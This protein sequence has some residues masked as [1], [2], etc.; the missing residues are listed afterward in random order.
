MR[1]LIWKEWHEQSWKLGFGCIVLSAMIVIGLNA[2]I[3]SDLIMVEWVCGI[4]VTILPIISATGLIPAERS[5]GT[6]E[7]LLAMPIAPWRILLAKTIAG[8]VLCVGPVMAAAIFTVIIAN[9][10]EATNADLLDLY[11]RT[12]LTSV[13]LLVWIM[14]LTIR[15]PTEGRAGLLAMGVLLLWVMVSG[16]LGIGSPRR[17]GFALSPF[18]FMYKFFAFQNDLGP[19]PSFILVLAVQAVVL[20]GVWFLARRTFVGPV[21]GQS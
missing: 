14:A 5:E 8:V 16:A 13:A 1:K 17:I 21:E 6:M 10:R 11:A 20:T 2:R 4:A 3:V 9:G 18:G 15:L 12:T 19:G 7:S